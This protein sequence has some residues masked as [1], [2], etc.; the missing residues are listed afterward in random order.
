[1]SLWTTI[2]SAYFPHSNKYWYRD[3][4]VGAPSW[5]AKENYDIE[6]KLD[7]A[8]VHSWK[9]LTIAQRQEKM[10]PMLQAMLA[11]RC[12]LAVHVVPAEIPGFSLVVGKHGAK[13]LQAKPDA[14]APSGGVALAAGGWIVPHARGAKPELT[15]VNVSMAT[16]A[17]FVM[18]SG[19][20]P[21][22][23]KTGLTGRYDLVIPKREGLSD[24][25]PEPSSEWRVEDLGL[26]LRPAKVP[27]VTVVIDHIERPS[28]N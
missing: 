18:V 19:A 11:E 14:P 23:D 7:E 4:L 27:T 16:V 24:S 3:R 5:M 26:E 20:R 28:E 8:T 15:L 6:A 17:E 12:K 25:D 22:Q 21:V 13:L 9:S 1:M 2:M 10:R